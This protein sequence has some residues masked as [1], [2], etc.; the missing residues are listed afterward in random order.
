[1][2]KHILPVLENNLSLLEAWS[3]YGPADMLLF[4]LEK[5]SEITSTSFNGTFLALPS[6]HADK[7]CMF[8]HNFRSHELYS[9]RNRISLFYLL[10]S[11]FP[12]GFHSLIS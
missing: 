8:L 4:T 2:K 7:S 9:A 6:L 1:M 12:I 10:F 5:T 3:S 11:Y